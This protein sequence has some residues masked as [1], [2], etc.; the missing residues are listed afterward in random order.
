MG[1]LEVALLIG[2][3][4]PSISAQPTVQFPINSQVP[5][6]AR[7]SQVFAFTFAEST[8]TSNAGTLTYTLEAQPAW[9]QLDNLS[10]TFSGTPASNDV[11]I[12][13]FRLIASDAQGLVDLPIT[14]MVEQDVAIGL[15]APVI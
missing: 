5:P 7:P 13:T 2:A 6:V 12:A 1:F 9:L 8:F 4:L 10:R 3:A 14:F 15:G 11:G